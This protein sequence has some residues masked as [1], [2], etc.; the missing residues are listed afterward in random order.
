MA[1][2]D[3]V[4]LGKGP[5][6]FAA[7]AALAGHGLAVGL[8]G[9]AGSLHWPA[10]YGA[11]EAELD[12]L[13]LHDL[14]EH[15]WAEAVVDLGQGDRRVLARPYVRIHKGRLAERLQQQCE[16]GGVHPLDGLAA[17][18]QH[19]ETDSVIRCADG[20]EIRARLVVDA[21]GHDPVLVRRSARPAR[22][23]QTAFGILIDH[24]SPLF[25]PDR[26][27]FMDW[28][29]AWMTPDERAAPPSFL[30]AL[31]LPGGRL[32]LEETVLVGRPAVPLDLLERRL[33]R[34]LSYLGIPDAP[35]LAEERCWIPMGGALPDRSQRTVGFGGAAGMV[36]PATGYLLTRVLASAPSLAEA[37]ALELGG[38]GAEPQRAARAAWN[39]LWPTDR[40][41]RRDLFCFGMEVLL[42]LD[43]QRTRAFFARFFSLPAPAWQAYVD[44]DLAA[45]ELRGIM[46]QLFAELPN[47][48]RLNLARAAVGRAGVA[49]VRSL[50]EQG[51]AGAR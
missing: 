16:A 6:G 8:L 42:Q 25:P 31:P 34:R 46:A 22:G 41:H 17:E 49:L 39:A 26:A 7:A 20:A 44:D 33:R 10:E 3:V 29:D 43:P 15:R 1:P 11:W 4:V 28:D 21:S 47:P 48:L 14:A 45:R 2:L 9:P 19:R 18:V 32:F 50:L 27:L 23:F 38:S 24:H 36:H 35:R 37:I 13:G 5:P 51:L 30:Y 40:R 12:R